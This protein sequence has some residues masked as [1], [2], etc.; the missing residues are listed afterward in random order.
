MRKLLWLMSGLLFAV[1]CSSKSYR[2]V[3]YVKAPCEKTWRLTSEHLIGDT[4]TI[5]SVC[6]K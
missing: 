4:L 3:D 2:Y 1:A 6:Q 5:V